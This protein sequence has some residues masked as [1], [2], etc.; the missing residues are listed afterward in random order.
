MLHEFAYCVTDVDRIYGGPPIVGFII[1]SK[2]LV[3]QLDS[4]KAFLYSQV[5]S[6]E[7]VSIGSGQVRHPWIELY[8]KSRVIFALLRW[9][10]V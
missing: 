6:S 3:Y 5:C 10:L 7:L 1:Q 9:L 8:L 2:F 4:I